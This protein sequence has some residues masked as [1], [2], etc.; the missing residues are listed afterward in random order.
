[1]IKSIFTFALIL[2]FSSLSIA[3]FST[4]TELR[5]LQLVNKQHNKE[6]I[7]GNLFNAEL[8]ADS[9]I[10]KNENNKLNSQFFY[11]LAES[12]SQCG[13]YDLALFSLLR[14]RCLFPDEAVANKSEPMFY[15]LAY[16]NNLT[17]SIARVLWNSSTIHGNKAINFNKQ[18][19]RLLNLSI[20]IARS[21]LDPFIYKS[22]LQLRSFNAN[23]PVWYQHW[24]F[25]TL[26]GMPNSDK[27]EIIKYSKDKDSAVYKQIDN[28]T[29]RNK[30]YRY[31]VRYYKESESYKQAANILTEYKAQNLNFFRRFEAWFMGLELRMS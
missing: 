15:E 25:L 13:K 10:I 12:Y 14:Q 31:A 4:K 26:I 28:S 11:E 18:L 9:I 20:S 24:E 1:M 6:L 16:K 5:Y 23:I 22:G 2:L 17:D 7:S 27:R 30:V 19:I 21:N 8:A 29:L 3:Q